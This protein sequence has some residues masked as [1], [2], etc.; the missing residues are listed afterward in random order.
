LAKW[1]LFPLTVRGSQSHHAGRLCETP[2]RQAAGALWASLDRAARNST[3]KP[4]A[5]SGG[6][7]QKTNIMKKNLIHTI[8]VFFA[9][10]FVV[11]SCKD[12]IS[13]T[14]VTLSETSISL[15]IGESLTLIATVEPDNATN[16]KHIWSS[17]NPAVASVADGKIIALTAGTTTITATTQ[18]GNRTAR[19]EVAVFAPAAS[20]TLSQ[21]TAALRVIDMQWSWRHL[22]LAATVTPDNAN[23][24]VMWTSNNTTVATIN[25][26]GTVTALTA[27][28]TVIT[29][30]TQEGNK[31]DTCIL[32]VTLDNYCNI[33]TPNFGTS[34]GEVSFASD[35]EWTITGNGITQIWSDAVTATACQKE[36]F[37]GG[38]TDGWSGR[39]PDRNYFADCRSNP[40]YPGNLFSGCAVNRF[41][42]VLCPA[43]WRVPTDQEQV[44]LDVALGGNGGNR[45]TDRINDAYLNPLVWGGTF[46]GSCTNTGNLVG[47]GSRVFYWSSTPNGAVDYRTEYISLESTRWYSRGGLNKASGVTLRCIK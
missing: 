9:L 3:E 29:A 33:N 41:A 21:S 13:V 36:T 5:E 37:F 7:K 27:G 45:Y 42:D 11:T 26:G 25:S 43:P 10:S 44:D 46:A 17:S 19:C 38:P 23:Q 15:T 8:I 2:L 22:T 12:P 30:T 40:G 39:E 28:T 34:L 47:Q 14:K 35:T 6:K 31:T 20:V 24:T 16:K 4:K 1:R 32:T 18:D